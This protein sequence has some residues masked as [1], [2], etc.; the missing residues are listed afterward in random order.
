MRDLTERVPVHV[1]DQLHAAVEVLTEQV[2]VV[3]A[4]VVDLARYGIV[5]RW[6]MEVPASLAPEEVAEVTDEEDEAAAD[7]L[8]IDLGWHT[9]EVLTRAIETAE[10]PTLRILPE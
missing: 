7:R 4:A 6:A 2:P 1:R 8:G 9:V 3:A 5:A 10:G